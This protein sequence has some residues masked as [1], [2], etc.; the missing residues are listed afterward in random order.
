MCWGLNGQVYFLL[1]LLTVASEEN[2]SLPRKMIKTKN[3]NIASMLNIARFSS[4][5][6]AMESN[7][8][9]ALIIVKKNR[10]FNETVT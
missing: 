2:G 4:R 10:S 1:G 7:Y 9:A 8:L 5:R 3:K 6:C